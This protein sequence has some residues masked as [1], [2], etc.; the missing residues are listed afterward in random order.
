[1]TEVG[2]TQEEFYKELGKHIWTDTFFSSNGR[3][4]T[5]HE[6]EMARN[7]FASQATAWRTEHALLLGQ[8]A[9]VAS[10][11]RQMQLHGQFAAAREYLRARINLDNTFD[12][13]FAQ[14]GGR[15]LHGFVQT[16]M[17]GNEHYLAAMLKVLIAMGST[18]QSP[19]E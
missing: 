14:P 4:P 8:L 6:L 11:A 2:P 3:Q 15:F 1:M 19:E 18:A 5:V 12:T 7:D 9:Q 13:L 10:T 17:H 16:R